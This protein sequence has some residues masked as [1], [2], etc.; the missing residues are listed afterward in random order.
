MTLMTN[1]KKVSALAQ[2]G[3]EFYSIASSD[4]SVTANGKNYYAVPS[5]ITIK[6]GTSLTYPI[7]GAVNA[8]TTNRLK[9]DLQV[10]CVGA[11]ANHYFFVAEINYYDTYDVYYAFEEEEGAG[12]GEVL[13]SDCKNIV[14]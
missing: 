13:K 12:V 4:T 6:Q 1:G 7:G 9:E 14:W 10:D 11:N 3:T 8:T 2:G 5:Q